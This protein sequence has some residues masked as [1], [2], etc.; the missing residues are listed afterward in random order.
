MCFSHY[1]Q[2]APVNHLQV[3]KYKTRRH[4]MTCKRKKK[5]STT[6]GFHKAVEPLVEIN[7]NGS[8]RQQEKRCYCSTSGNTKDVTYFFSKI[9]NKKQNF[10]DLR[11]SVSL[12]FSYI[13]CIQHSPVDVFSDILR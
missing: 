10:T 9:R 1:I 4:S 8:E 2:T 11:S 13:E 6:V 12:F 7:R 5:K 3:E